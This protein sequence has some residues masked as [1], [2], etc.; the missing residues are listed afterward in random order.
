MTQPE[1]IIDSWPITTDQFIALLDPKSPEKLEALGGTT[2]VIEKLKTNAETGL[3]TDSTDRSVVDGASRKAYYGENQLPQPRQKSFFEFVWDAMHDKI[4]ILLTVAA[5]VEIAIGIYKTVTGAEQFGYLDGLAVTVAVV[6]VVLVTSVN[7]WR[8]Q[9]QFRKLN[10]FGRSLLMCKVVRDS[11]TI[12][13]P[14]TELLVGDILCVE[15][16]DVLPADGL[17]VSGYNIQCDESA[18]TGEP[19]GISKNHT[20]DPFFLSGTK[21][22]N[23]IGKM[24]VIGVG[25]N[26][27]NGRSMLA[28]NVEA[29]ITPL[30][31]KLAQ[32]ADQIA[33]LGSGAALLMIILLIILLFAFPT[34]PTTSVDIIK[35]LTDIFISA[36]TLVVVAVPE[37]LPL[38]VTLSLAYA[39]IRM[40]KDNNLV[41]HLMA[42]ETMGNATTICSDKT[43]TLTLNKMTVVRGVLIENPF[44][45]DDIP[46][47][48]LS[49]SK[50]S[51]LEKLMSLMSTSINLNSTA[52]ETTNDKG[53]TEFVGSKTEV[54][55]LQFTA[56]L[57]FKYAESREKTTV[58]E[59]IPFSS[60]RKRMGTVVKIP[61]DGV[62]EQT[63]GFPK[64]EQEDKENTYLLFNKGASEIILGGCK[65]YV[66]SN[67]KIVPMTER[68][69][70]LF[71][72]YIGAFASEALRTIALAFKPVSGD[73]YQKK[74]KTDDETND[75]TTEG[76]EDNTDLT[77]LI[78]F[79]IV[80]IQDP[81]RPEVPDAVKDC[82]SA[83]VVVRM[84]TGDNLA[85][86]RAIARGC[87]ILSQDGIV[88]EGPQFRQLTEEEMDDIL[89]NLQVL[90]R[91]SPQDKQILVNNLRRLGETVA[92]TGDGTNDAPALKA[93]DVG[94]SMGIAGTE[95]AKEASDIVLMDDNFASL[96]KAVIWGLS[97]YDSV[98]KFLQ[99][100]LTVNV[101]AVV[102]TI[103][104]SVISTVRYQIPV[105]AL[106]AVQLLWIN[107][108]MDTFAALALATDAATPDLLRRNPSN[109]FE[110]L[111]SFHMWR[112]IVGQSIYQVGVCLF[113]YEAG[114]ELW[115]A[116]A[117]KSGGQG[118][119]K[120]NGGLDLHT[121]G[122]IFN[123][124]V[125][126]QVF[127]MINSRSLN[128]DF[129]IIRNAH[130]NPYLLSIWGGTFLVQ[131]ILLQYGGLIFKT[132]PNGLDGI[133]WLICLAFGVGSIILGALIRL[134]PDWRKE[135]PD[136]EKPVVIKD[137]TGFASSFKNVQEKTAGDD[138]D[139]KDKSK[140]PPSDIT[141][142]SPLLSNAS[143]P[144]ENVN[145]VTPS[146]E[147]KD[148]IDLKVETGLVVLDKVSSLVRNP[149]GRIVSTLP[150]SV[151]M[152][153]FDTDGEKVIGLVPQPLTP[154]FGQV[155]TAEEYRKARA[156][157]GWQSLR[158][159]LTV[160]SAFKASGSLNVKST[161][162]AANSEIEL[163][164]RRNSRGGK[165]LWAIAKTQTM[166]RI[167]VVQAFRRAKREDHGVTML[168]DP[169]EYNNARAATLKKK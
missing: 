85:T 131:V 151:S 66:N 73:S 42:C 116:K 144:L 14:V 160:V 118:G 158:T 96:V 108:I 64:V 7:D 146:D 58:V 134:L 95:V 104:T 11:Q 162:S 31:S 83:G 74:P 137:R 161:G 82:Q 123:T 87:G 33:K 164:P 153:E 49:E 6:L 45:L 47:K 63:C 8:K 21:V 62:F 97:V 152:V 15:G 12:S 65:S 9:A 163:L 154:D 34:R 16:G 147:K 133:D 122:M 55:L 48:I 105:A 148:K 136:S 54:A 138:H 68:S 19:M 29:D 103:V 13:I 94:F 125:L 43:G 75:E 142:E 59:V 117:N 67:G 26:S 51:H 112:Q 120:E 86:A 24:L 110:S 72:Q 76:A 25:P 88:M 100:Q 79:G 128:R 102:I 23:G 61:K 119:G 36:V 52:S 106:T 39:T 20:K 5:V 17:F 80:G 156:H 56:K 124:F 27:V 143:P 107:L 165:E 84:V 22:V 121:A 130:K 89:P 91:S 28:L 1:L 114:K 57:G 46:T 145:D 99:F 2:A 101:A 77:D 93:A 129:N 155:L 113:L 166:R 98:R 159:R 141:S 18:Q 70:K 41:R 78:L 37:G 38:A 157:A 69:K 109:R 44:Q 35:G 53:V 71:E 10:D 90:A 150:N 111:V 139:R 115:P 30:Q 3:K 4:L 60:L 40:L 169:Y 140:E 126:M 135:L 149:S 32:L 50:G 127:N 167:S 168:M 92:V 81:L 132:D